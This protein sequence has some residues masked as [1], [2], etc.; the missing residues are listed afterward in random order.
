MEQVCESSKISR[1]MHPDYAQTN[2]LT[3]D[4]HK[5][6]R[7]DTDRRTHLILWSKPSGRPETR[8][9]TGFYAAVGFYSSLHSL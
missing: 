6:Q 2:V 8:G 3:Y 7:S 9:I 5:K 1:A 4:I